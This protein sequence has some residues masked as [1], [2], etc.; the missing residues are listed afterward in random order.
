[1]FHVEPIVSSGTKLLIQE[2]LPN[3]NSFIVP[4]NPKQ[5]L[6]GVSGQCSHRQTKASETAQLTR[7]TAIKTPAL[8]MIV[9]EVE[10]E[11]RGRAGTAAGVHVAGARRIIKSVS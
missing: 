11:V 3:V 6:L 10:V 2:I 7:S 9:V 8:G 4:T 5:T 1:M